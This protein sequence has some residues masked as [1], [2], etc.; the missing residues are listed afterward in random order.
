MPAVMPLANTAIRV[1]FQLHQGTAV[2]TVVCSETHSPTT[3]DLGLFSLEVGNG[4]RAPA[5]SRPSTGAPGPYSLGWGW[6][7]QVGAATQRGCP[8]AVERALYATCEDRRDGPMMRL[9]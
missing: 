6:T 2:G 4:T 5:P 3:N 8:A 9:R 1:Q 7:L